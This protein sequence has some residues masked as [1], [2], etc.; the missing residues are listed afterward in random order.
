MMYASVC[1]VPK[2]VHVFPVKKGKTLTL[3]IDVF[4]FSLLIF[5]LHVCHYY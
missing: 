3:V 2:F 5:I 1:A 4:L